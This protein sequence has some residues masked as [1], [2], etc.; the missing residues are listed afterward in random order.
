VILVVSLNP[1]LDITHHVAGADWSGVNRPHEVAVRPGGKGVNVARTLRGLGCDVLVTGLAGGP[2]GGTL[3]SGLDAAGLRADLTPIAAETRRTF[4]VVDTAHGRTGLFNE[5][6]PPVTQAEYDRFRARYLA[7]LGDCAA[8]TLSGSLPSGLAP[9]T[10][11]ELTGLAAAAGLPVILDTDGPALRLGAAARPAIVKPNLAELERSVGRP[12]RAP[13]LSDVVGPPL[14]L[15]RQQRANHDVAH[16]APDLADVAAAARELLDEGARAAVVTL[17]PAGL[18][19]VTGEGTW[20]A[21]PPG[22]A[23]GNPTGAGDAVVAGLARGLVRGDD[24]PGRLRHAVALGTAAV[25]AP[26]AGEFSPDRY[27]ELLPLVR[28]ERQAS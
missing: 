2:S 5:P 9:G 10:Y 27:R 23:E 4:A 28:V 24:W 15:E 21:L 6:G 3:R 17:G 19:A 11:A 13:S 18:L 16:P 8:V 20:R 25:A 7:A 1:A 14:S 12:V 22:P 26:V